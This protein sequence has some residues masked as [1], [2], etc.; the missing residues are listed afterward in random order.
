MPTSKITPDRFDELL[1]YQSMLGKGADNTEPSWVGA[2]RLTDGTYTMSYPKY[3]AVVREFF[4]L[5]G[6]ECWSDYGYDPI[7]TG[8]LIERDDVIASASLEQLRTML[9][10]CVRG[11]RFCDGHW[12]AMIREGRVASILRR[13]E[14]LRRDA[15]PPN[16]SL[17]RTREG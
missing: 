4:E 9:T 6:Q 5:A 13:L 15:P 17:E 10:Y 16:K 7:R 1:R 3:P 11:E 8:E 2:E 12:G 14:Q